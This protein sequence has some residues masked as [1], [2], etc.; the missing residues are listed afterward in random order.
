M[1]ERLQTTYAC[2]LYLF[3]LYYCDVVYVR[4]FFV[5]TGKSTISHSF[6]V[7]VWVLYYLLDSAVMTSLTCNNGLAGVS[8][9]STDP[10]VLPCRV[11]S[12]W[13]LLRNRKHDLKHL[14]GIV[15]DINF[16]YCW[17]ADWPVGCDTSRQAP[18]SWY[19][20]DILVSVDGIPV[21]IKPKYLQ[22]VQI[23]VCRSSRWYP[24]NSGAKMYYALQ[25]SWCCVNRSRVAETKTQR[26]DTEREVQ[27]PCY[28]FIKAVVFNLTGSLK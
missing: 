7:Q 14:P 11:L 1:P 17:D 2:Y 10:I 25:T 18:Q 16:K 3:S 9:Q 5:I 22:W 15:L 6:K 23:F 21:W 8:Y 12:V 13:R 19:C 26:G 28:Y 4:R 27:H 24:C 20:W